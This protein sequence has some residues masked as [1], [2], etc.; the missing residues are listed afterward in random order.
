MP[1][2]PLFLLLL[3]ARGGRLAVNST[4]YPE[5]ETTDVHGFVF[6]ALS[7]LCVEFPEIT[8]SPS[9]KPGELRLF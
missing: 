1:G 5:L 7:L 2:V 8:A 4:L 6:P 3:T 9:S